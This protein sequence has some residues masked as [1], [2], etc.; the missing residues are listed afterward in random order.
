MGKEIK[1]L[2]LNILL[3]GLKNLDW[4]KNLIFVFLDSPGGILGRKF[5]ILIKIIFLLCLWC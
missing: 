5:E 2:K 4:F 3:T 1:K